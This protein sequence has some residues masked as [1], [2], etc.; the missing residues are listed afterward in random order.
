MIKLVR[1]LVILLA[2]LV[3]AAVV[4]VIVGKPYLERVA[5]RAITERFGGP[6]VTVK[7]KTP[8]DLGVL[9]GELGDITVTS[10]PFVRE[11]LQLQ[12]ASATYRNATISYPS[13]LERT[14]G[15]K[16]SSVAFSVST[17]IP[18]IQAFLREQL[19]LRGLPGATGARVLI[20][21]KTLL[22]LSGALRMR[23][24]LA[25]VAPD[26]IRI[27]PLS[28]SPAARRALAASIR[29]GPL[30]DGVSLKGVRL[31]DASAI[32]TGGGPAGRITIRR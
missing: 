30:P 13:L 23:A 2:L 15:L 32:L 7:L 9:S 27:V 20:R 6:E 12:S 8:H 31:Q 10:E 29:L 3:A 18:A 19:R 28:G 22:V 25:V 4:G 1:R 11:K 26:V 5:G 14:F 24:A 21:P 16:Y 17:G